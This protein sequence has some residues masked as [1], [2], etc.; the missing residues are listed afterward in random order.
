[1]GRWHHVVALVCGLLACP[2]AR[3]AEQGGEAWPAE[4]RLVVPALDLEVWVRTSL[5]LSR[6]HTEMYC[7]RLELLARELFGTAGGGEQPPKRRPTYSV[8]IDHEGKVDLGSRALVRKARG[9]VFRGG[10]FVGGGEERRWVLPVRRRCTIRFAL[11]KRVGE[12]FI[13][14]LRFA[15]R[16]PP[17]WDEQL[18]GGVQV[19]SAVRVAGEATPKCPVRLEEARA[20]ALRA[21]E[22][23]RYALR[24]EILR[25]LLEMKIVRLTDVRG[26]PAGGRRRLGLYTAHVSVRNHTPW[27]V[28]RFRGKHFGTCRGRDRVLCVEL[29]FSGS[30]PPG[31]TQ[32]VPCRATEYVGEESPPSDELTDVR[33]SLKGNPR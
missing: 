16:E 4:R 32:V 30:I 29:D 17:T 27:H 10:A 25:R 20:K 33:W 1:M 23:P 11:Y 22:P 26:A 5:R 28:H 14:P 3:G 13:S 15:F 6:E 8:I 31:R 18:Y 7:G 21:I 9:R 19:A 2:A 12:D 24:P